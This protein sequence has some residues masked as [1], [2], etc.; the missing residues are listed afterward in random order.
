MMEPDQPNCPPDAYQRALA[1][2]RLV[3]ATSTNKPSICRI[4][5]AGSGYDY[6]WYQVGSTTTPDK[7]YRVMLGEGDV[8]EG[9]TCT[10]KAHAQLCCVHRA[11][12]FLYTKAQYQHDETS[13]AATRPVEPDPTEEDYQ[14][15]EER[16][17]PP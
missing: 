7:A 4:S 10:C 5:I 14:G 2:A 13:P 16:K 8:L 17:V 15:Y 9:A 1:R 11:L 6:H 12:A 3:L